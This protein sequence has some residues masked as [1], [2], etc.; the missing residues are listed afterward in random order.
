MIDL[1]N[2]CI[3]VRTPEENKKLIATEKV[4]KLPNIFT[5]V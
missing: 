1:R 3:L 2:T 4:N 5:V